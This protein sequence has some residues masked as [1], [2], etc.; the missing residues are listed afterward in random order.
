MFRCDSFCRLWWYWG[1]L[2]IAKASGTDSLKGNYWI[3]RFTRMGMFDLCLKGIKKEKTDYNTHKTDYEI[4]TLDSIS[5]L[6]VC[7]RGTY[8]VDM[9]DLAWLNKFLRVGSAEIYNSDSIE[10]YYSSRISCIVSPPLLWLYGV[11]VATK[12]VVV[13]SVVY[14]IAHFLFATKPNKVTFSRCTLLRRL[15]IWQKSNCLVVYIIEVE[16]AHFFYLCWR[17]KHQLA[18]FVVLRMRYLNVIVSKARARYF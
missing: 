6:R 7:N 9:W 5:G 15:V 13:L 4:L 1:R 14:C 18:Y 17:C 10:T 16:L 8:V 12:Q 11:R 3:P 2:D